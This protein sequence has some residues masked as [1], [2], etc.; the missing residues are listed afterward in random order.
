MRLF[1][2]NFEA[3]GFSFSLQ[4]Q[5][6]LSAFL[7]SLVFLPCLIFRFY[8]LLLI[9]GDGCFF[10]IFSVCDVFRIPI[11]SQICAG[12][13]DEFVLIRNFSLD[14]LVLPLESHTWSNKPAILVE[15]EFVLY[16]KEFYGSVLKLELLFRVAIFFS[17]IKNKFAFYFTFFSF[18]FAKS[19]YDHSLLFVI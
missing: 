5:I 12:L 3:M 19:F 8:F 15:V 17:S 13:Y 9:F 16:R 4:L 1:V 10:C 6:A 18:A 14:W 11:P 2:V 7:F